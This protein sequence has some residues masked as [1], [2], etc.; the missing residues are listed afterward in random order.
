MSFT[1]GAGTRFLLSTD[2]S[3][4]LSLSGPLSIT[5]GTVTANNPIL[6][7]TQTWNNAAVTF[8]GWRLNVTDTASNAASLLLDLQ[9][10]GSSRFSVAKN[11]NL[12]TNVITTD[13][14]EGAFIFSSAS[15]NVGSSAAVVVSN[16]DGLGTNNGRFQWVFPSSIGVSSIGV[17]GWGSDV[18]LWR[19]AANTL[20]QRNGVNAQTLRVYN[21]FTDASN[22]ERGKIEWAS[23]V[24][25]IGTEKAG[26]GTA[27]G[28]E[29]QTDGATRLSIP[30]TDVAGGG[31]RFD[32]VLRIAQISVSN[33]VPTNYSQQ[34]FL[35]A[36]DTTDA[37]MYYGL[38]V[39]RSRAAAPVNSSGY[40]LGTFS[41]RVNQTT[42]T[43]T[44]S[45]YIRTISTEVHS[46]TALGTRM[47][48]GTT[49]NG[50]TT[51][52]ERLALEASGILTFG[53][54]TSSFPALKRNTTFLETKLAD[55]S[56]YAPH[57]MQYLDITDGVTAP[58]SAA[59]RA[60]IYV[61]TA[62]GDLKVIFGDGTVKT[63]VVDTP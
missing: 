4:A 48:F 8:T 51:V 16:F 17:V 2:S 9:V 11:G 10:G 18:K 61:D 19:D 29:F 22:Y 34:G 6:S 25:R 27:R 32:S 37:A 52:T 56:A 21:T 41:T 28:L 24:L 23:N 39:F 20:A 63:I 45:A 40:A 43:W 49:A 54:N 5:G 7:A 50:S 38:T 31:V 44:E 59:G 47:S 62:D 3:G 42:N 12:R 33:A 36:G 53:S 55:D 57:A 13:V 1:A 35:S 46:N 14:S 15:A 60:R 58:A 30:V 26:T